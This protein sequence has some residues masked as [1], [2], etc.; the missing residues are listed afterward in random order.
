[1]PDGF[2]ETSLGY[3]AIERAQGLTVNNFDNVTVEVHFHAQSVSEIGDPSYLTVSF[4]LLF[5]G[6]E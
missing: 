3:A 4:P 6:R 1:M 2:A 5:S